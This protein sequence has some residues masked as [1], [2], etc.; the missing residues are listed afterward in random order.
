MI[1]FQ[2]LMSRKARKKI[3]LIIMLVSKYKLKIINDFYKNNYFFV[4]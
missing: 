3:N 2:K 1:I 4:C